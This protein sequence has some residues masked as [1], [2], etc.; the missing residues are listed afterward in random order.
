ME[1]ILKELA[2]A[3]IENEA[4]LDAKIEGL[5]GEEVLKDK[6]AVLKIKSTVK[7]ALKIMGSLKKQLPAGS[8]KVMQQLEEMAGMKKSDVKKEG[9]MPAPEK[10]EE[11]TD[12]TAVLKE[13]TDLLKEVR[14]ENKDLKEQIAKER[15]ERLN[16]EYVAKAKD[17]GFAGEKAE[18]IAKSLRSAQENMPEE[19]Y[20]TFV[21]TLKTQNEQIA[22]SPIMKEYGNGG[23]VSTDLE[24][25]MTAAKE[26]IQKAHPEWSEAKVEAEVMERN[27]ELY[28]QYLDENP[29][30]GG[31]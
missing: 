28:N 3:K 23:K 6:D 27:P 14:E 26:S 12:V 21:D 15:N 20:N 22:N 7:A 16:K 2:A 31:Y 10:K 9:D 29:K 1:D 30:Q 4:E 17:L 11:N 8:E 24:A 25:K 19:E 18:K 5:L 13:T